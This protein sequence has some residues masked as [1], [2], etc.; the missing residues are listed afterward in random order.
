MITAAAVAVVAIAVAAIVG[1]ILVGLGVAVGL[2]LGVVN[3]LGMRRMVNRMAAIGSANKRAVA[4]ASLSR[5]GV[6]T[7]VVFLLLL[8][9]HDVAFGALGGLVVFQGAILANSSRI[10]MSQIR[11]EARL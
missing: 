11:R 5:L 8:I 2:S 10:L 7:A 3:A 4:G 1:Y 9:N 6:I